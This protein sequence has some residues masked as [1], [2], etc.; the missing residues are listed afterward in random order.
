MAEPK[1][2]RKENRWGSGHR[3]YEIEPGLQF[4]SVTT[5]LEIIGKPALIN[6]AAKVE[7]ELV[8]QC[9]ADL[10]QDAPLATRMSRTGWITTMQSRL[11]NEKAHKRLL[12]KAGNI[13]TQIHKLVEWSLK[14]ELCMEAGPSP[15][16]GPEAQAAYNEWL[17]WRKDVKLKPLFIEHKV[18]SR[19]H[20]YAGTLD[21]FAEVEGKPTVFD[22]KSGKA[23]YAEAHL[24]NAAYRH[25]WREMGHGD[26]V[27][28]IIVRLPKTTE[29]PDFEAVQ[30]EPE[31]GCLEVFLHTLRLWIWTQQMEARRGGEL[32]E[33]AEVA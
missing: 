31:S 2:I 1:R 28:G 18:Y 15:Q 17:K 20:G 5:I 3:F 33:V 12:T 6:W 24:Q 32:Q 11:T 14:A 26:P 23:V 8:L 30:A 25:A 27:Q 16:I 22:W 9:S 19:T 10:Y 13:G 29:D 7:R 4:P 21:L